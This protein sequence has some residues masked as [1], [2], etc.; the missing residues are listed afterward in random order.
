MALDGSDE[1]LWKPRIAQCRGGVQARGHWRAQQHE[2]GLP[3]TSLKD[4]GLPE[5]PCTWT[6]LEVIIST[7]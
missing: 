4:L 3:K 6:C 7:E 5:P 1:I 2:L